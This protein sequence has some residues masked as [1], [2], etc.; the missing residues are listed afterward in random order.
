ML[1]TF[2][3]SRSVS[4]SQLF[5]FL[6]S[7]IRHSTLRSTSSKSS[8]DVQQCDRLATTKRMRLLGLQSSQTCKALAIYDD[9]VY[10]QKKV[11]DL[12]MFAVAINCAMV[13]EDL[14]KGREI[15][16]L[17][18]RDYPHLK[19]NLMLKQQLRYFY[20]KCNDQPSADKL[21]QQSSKTQHTQTET[22][23]NEK[24]RP[25]DSIPLIKNKI[26]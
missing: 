15:H 1:W 9:Y 20:I 21:F 5:V 4:F 8:E 22:Q 24:L 19:D 2:A 26:K 3:Y 25:L 13:A 12:R 17:I 16:Q 14:A 6:S 10:R 11:P 7:T 23:H 18:E